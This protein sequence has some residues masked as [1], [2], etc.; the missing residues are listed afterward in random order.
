[1]MYA[2]D[3]PCLPMGCTHA[4]L[5]IDY[6]QLPVLCVQPS[7]VVR[8]CAATPVSE[9]TVWGLNPVVKPPD[10]RLQR[11]KGGQGPMKLAE[12]ERTRYTIWKKFAQIRTKFVRISYQIY[13]N[14]VRFSQKLLYSHT[15]PR[16]SFVPNSY[17]FATNS[18]RISSNVEKASKHTNEQGAH[19]AITRA[20]DRPGPSARALGAVPR[21]G[22]VPQVP[23]C[24]GPEGWGQRWRWRSGSPAPHRR[25]PPW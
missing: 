20:A 1:M 8:A 9:N 24:G 11:G 12:T 13:T 6:A 23:Q 2:P 10:M 25:C 16:H 21:W 3:R 15:C 18:V 22:G 17:K 14:F 4:T 7:A 19:L 5:L